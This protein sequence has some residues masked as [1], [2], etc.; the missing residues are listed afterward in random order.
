MIQLPPGTSGRLAFWNPAA[1]HVKK[2]HP[3]YPERP[4]EEA[5]GRDFGPSTMLAEL[6]ADSWNQ[7]AG[8]MKEPL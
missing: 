7:F 4:L 6:S 1:A 3:P 8:H 5:T 2:P